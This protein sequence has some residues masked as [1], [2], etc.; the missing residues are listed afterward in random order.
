MFKSFSLECFYYHVFDGHGG[1]DI[2][3]MLVWVL[4]VVLYNA[5]KAGESYRVNRFHVLDLKEVLDFA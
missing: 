1:P 2:T 4:Y 3:G 5:D